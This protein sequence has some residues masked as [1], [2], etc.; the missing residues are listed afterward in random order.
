LFFNLNKKPL[1]GSKIGKVS[2]Y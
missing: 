1:S 2:L